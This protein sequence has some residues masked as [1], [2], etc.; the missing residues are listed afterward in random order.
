MY[1][2]VAIFG[3][4]LIGG[5]IGI[6]LKFREQA[7]E[8]VGVGRRKES[9]KK[10]L[11]FGCIDSYTLDPG[12][13]FA[14]ADLIIL[15]APVSAVLE[16]LKTRFSFLEKRHYLITDA[17]STKAVIVKTAEEFLPGNLSFVGGHPIAGSE[18]NGPEA[19]DADLFKNRITVLT[20]TS[21][22]RKPDLAAV[23]SFWEG[24]DSRVALLS[25]DKHDLTLA[26][27]SHTPHFL[28][29]LAALLVSRSKVSGREK[30]IGTGFRD[31]TRV[32]G[33]VPSLW[34]DIFLTNREYLLQNLEVLEKIVAEWKDA[35]QKGD[36]ERILKMLEEARQFQQSLS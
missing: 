16:L 11:D 33:S 5:S 35:L 32:S 13:G 34:A 8:I 30:F 3:V 26:V 31:I 27:T 18:K 28:S 36:Q 17:C 7:G 24:L 1:R 2:K 20:P 29:V 6:A 19:A 25:P 14:D 10:A 4:G 12:E 22:T 23:Q 21:K 9:L 15:A